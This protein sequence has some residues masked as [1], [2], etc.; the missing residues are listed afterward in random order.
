VELEPQQTQSVSASLGRDALDAG[1]LAAIIGLILVFVYMVAYY[2]LL[3]FI[4]M[5]SLLVAGALLWT[6]V[7]WLGE[8]QGLALTL[9]GVTGI[10]LS[11]GVAVDSNVVFYEHLKEDYY[12]GRSLRST[13]D[14]SFASAFST[15]LKA[16]IA[17]LIG[18]AILYFLTV[19]PVRGFALFLGLST[20]LDLV[21]SYFFMRPLTLMLVRL[22]S[23]QDRPAWFGMPRQRHVTP[24]AQEVRA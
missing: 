6:V 23:L 4:A 21:A 2:R 11:I 7:A 18:A 10:I 15:I 22:P 12:R 14:G 8:S 5:C 13:V 16:D 24:E 19:G 9:A 20:V 1:I 17:S 3:G